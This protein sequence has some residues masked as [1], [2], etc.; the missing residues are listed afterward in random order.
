MK[1]S[2]KLTSL[3]QKRK[4]TDSFRIL[5][6][7]SEEMVDLSSNDYLGLARNSVLK[8]RI[9]S[10]LSSSKRN[11]STGSRLI[12]GNNSLIEKTE[13]YLS[14]L[15]G[16][17]TATI[18]NSGYMANLAFFSSVPQRGDTIIY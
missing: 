11:G 13:S 12:T 7:N 10:S 16:Q 4:D 14:N 15:F 1:D 17:D 3:L 18:F 6:S 8:N 9:E 2:P 5:K